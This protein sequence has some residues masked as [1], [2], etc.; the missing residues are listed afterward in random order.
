MWEFFLPPFPTILFSV[1][2]TPKKLGMNTACHPLGGWGS[3][4]IIK[5]LMPMF[6]KRWVQCVSG[7]DRR[8]RKGVG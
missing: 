7:G 4:A 8:G 3:T 1:S 6:N 2:P 5:K